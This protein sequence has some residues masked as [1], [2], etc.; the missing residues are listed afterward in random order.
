VGSLYAELDE[1]E[2]RIA[3]RNAQR[4]PLDSKAAEAANM[5]EAELMSHVVL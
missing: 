1:L 2:A 5:R 4:Q 3:E